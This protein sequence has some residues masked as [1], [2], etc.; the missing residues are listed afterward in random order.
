MTLWTLTP[1]QKNL[2]FEWG[3]IIIKSSLSP[4]SSWSP[5]HQV[6]SWSFFHVFNDPT[7]N[8]F[9][10]DRNFQPGSNTTLPSEA[11][12][13]CSSS[14]GSIFNIICVPFFIKLNVTLFADDSWSSGGT[15]QLRLDR[16]S[17]I[18]PGRRT[19]KPL[20]PNESVTD[21]W[22]KYRWKTM[23]NWWSLSY[24][25]HL[26]SWI[27]QNVTFFGNFPDHLS[28]HFDFF[29]SYATIVSLRS[30][31]PFPVSLSTLVYSQSTLYSVYS[32]LLQCSVFFELLSLT[33]VQKMLMMMMISFTVSHADLIYWHSRYF[34]SFSS[35][36]SLTETER[37]L[38]L[39]MDDEVTRKERGV[40]PP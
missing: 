23:M 34:A 7:T 24:I 20:W 3:L 11:G 39:V 38:L 9:N 33:R 29:P 25:R 15:T 37:R 5:L 31:W 35:D 8:V 13:C 27:L 17:K 28:S 18:R 19:Q 21:L 4:S 10:N 40:S 22:V 30:F 26:F 2:I 16:R 14:S 6:W 36:V 12:Q 32:L 1:S